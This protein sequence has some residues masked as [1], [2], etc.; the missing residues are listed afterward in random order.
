MRLLSHML[1]P[2]MPLS[3]PG[4]TIP[5]L[6]NS[7]G[8]HFAGGAGAHLVGL[9]SVSLTNPSSWLHVSQGAAMHGGQY[10]TGTSVLSDTSFSDRMQGVQPASISWGQ[11]LSPVGVMRDPASGTLQWGSMGPPASWISGSNGGIS[12]RGSIVQC[13]IS[14][15]CTH[16]RS[17]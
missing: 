3:P 12:S 6:T 16:P 17:L 9:Q 13:P 11:M 15:V 8:A 1:L 10:P 5:L 14:T 2:G 7:T 4:S